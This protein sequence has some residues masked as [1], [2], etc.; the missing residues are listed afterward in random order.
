MAQHVVPVCCTP[1]V[2]L[3][4]RGLRVRTYLERQIRY[5]R[6]ILGLH[7]VQLFCAATVSLLRSL[8]A[9]RVDG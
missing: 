4:K 6:L 5:G 3:S 7:R 2:F 1:T 9:T 8:V